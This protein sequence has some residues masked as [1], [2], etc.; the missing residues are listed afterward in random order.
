M[1]IDLSFVLSLRCN[2]E[3]SFCMY[4]SSPNNLTEIDWNLLENFIKT[5]DFDK[6]RHI[7]YF[8]G[9]ISIMLETYKKLSE[10]LPKNFPK[11]CITNGSWSLNKDKTE[12][13]LN[14]ILNDNFEYIKISSTS[15][16]QKYQNQKVINS[17]IDKYDNFYIKKD[18]LKSNLN[19]MGKLNNLENNCSKLCLN[20]EIIPRYTIMPDNSIIYQVCDGKNP[21]IS[22]INETFSSLLNKNIDCKFLY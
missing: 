22:T 12:E 3:C 4:D 9:E 10:L 19:P 20:K 21:I 8:G 18:D 11:F 14:F 5:I 15:E 2:L 7:G 6:I 17:I 13:L 16:H 1:K